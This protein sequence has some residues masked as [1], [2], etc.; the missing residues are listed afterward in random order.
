MNTRFNKKKKRKPRWLRFLLTTFCIFAIGI[1]VYIYNFY[2][3]VASAIDNMNKPMERKVSDKRE[4]EVEFTR[5]DPISILLVGVDERDGD[6]GRTDSMLVMT[7]NP[8][9]KSTKI[10]SIPRD[11]RAKLID[12]DDPDEYKLDKMNHA[13]AFGG[14]EMTINSIEHFLNVPIDYY[15]EVNME[16]F[17]DIVDA[18]GGIDVY[19]QYE[20][21]LDGTFLTE[22]EHHLNGEEALQYSRMRKEDPRGDFGRQERQR[23]VISKVIDKGTSLKSLTNYDDMLDALENNIKTNL[24][25]NEMIGIQ[26]QYKPAAESMEKLE[27]EGTGE[28]LKNGVWYFT[29]DDETRQALSDQ[30]REHLGLPIETVESTPNY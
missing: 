2:T 13:Y 18:V 4:E 11:T 24:T 6:S 5:K 16:G 20:F 30:L 22:G 1:G 15:T 9:M 27:I 21:E 17:R 14:I 19:N 12:N 3:N 28:T 8:D 7:I 25:L 10:V 29:V 26:R 23:E